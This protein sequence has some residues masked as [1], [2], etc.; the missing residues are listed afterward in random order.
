MD[1]LRGEALPVDVRI[2]GDM[3][4]VVADSAVHLPFDRH[5]ADGRDLPLHARKDVRHLLA[6]R[7]RRRR[8]PVRAG[9]HR[10]IGVRMRKRAQR[11]R[12]VLERWQQDRAPRLDQHEPVRKVV[13]VLRRAREVDEFGDLSDLRNPGEPLLLPIFD[14]LYVVVGRALDH[15]YA[16]AVGRRECRGCCVGCRACRRGERRDFGNLR[17]LGER[18]EPCDLDAHAGADQ[19]EFGEMLS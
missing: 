17:F 15:L 8:L 14:R 5:V 2:R 10:Q 12:D 7:C 4:V 9:E 11:G 1:D 18:D 3:R 16:F 6:E 13:D 19:T